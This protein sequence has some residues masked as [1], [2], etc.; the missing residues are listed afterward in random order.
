[1]AEGSLAGDVKEQQFLSSRDDLLAP[2]FEAMKPEELHRIGAEAEK[3]GVDASTGAALPYEGERSVLTVLGA[4]VERHGWTPEPEKPGGPLIALLRRGA[5]VTLEPGGQLELSGAPLENIHQICLEMSGHLAELRDIS[6]EL[7]L[8]WLGI[9][10]HPF[11]RQEDLTWVPKGRY[12]IMQRYLPTRGQYGHDMMRRTCTVQANFDYASEEKAMRAMRVTL[13]LSPLVTAMFANSPFYEGKPFGGRSYRARV[14]L[15]VDPSRQ[16]LIQRVMEDGQ[17]FFDYV[18]WA[19][20]APM[21]LIKRDGKVLDNTSQTFREF[22]EHGAHGYRATRSDWETHLNTMFPEVRLKRT[23]EVRGADSLP[24]NL[25]CALPALWTGILYDAQAL[26]EAEALSESYTYDE[27]MALR[28]AI[29]EEALQATFRGKKLATYAERLLEISAGGLA[30]RG[31]VNK[32]GKDE[33]VHLERL[34]GLVSR[35]MSPAD[36]MLEQLGEGGSDP[37]RRI[38]ELARI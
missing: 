29:A 1:M 9:G 28:P 13:R 27:L 15:D 33:R 14:W 23:I 30:R 32:N 5:S 10:F 31:R 22:M 37:R 6:A 16:G 26:D 21:F 7:H 17:S 38:L 19:L 11:A 34:G 3:F 25:I 8:V 20:D 36:A 35:G 2:F 18:E 4:L 24:A 12:P